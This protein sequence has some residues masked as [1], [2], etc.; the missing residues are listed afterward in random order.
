MKN[1]FCSMV[2]VGLF[3]AGASAQTAPLY[4]IFLDT[5]GNAGSDAAPH[6]GSGT[7]SYGNPN[8]PNGG[9]RLFIYG[10]FQLADQTVLS[11]N[12]DITVDGGTITG[13]WNY[14]GLGQDTLTG[15]RRWGVASPN[16]L[17]NPGGNT[18]SFTSGNII[19]M[20]LKNGIFADNF[21][22]QHDNTN[23]FGDTLLGYADVAN[24]PGVEATVWITVGQQGFAILGGNQDSGV[25]FGFGDPSVRAGDVGRRTQ[26]ADATIVP[27]PAGFMLLGLGVLA[28]TFLERI[29]TARRSS[30]IED[31]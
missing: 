18:V 27:E 23:R 13:A 5:S 7:L 24:D 31:A 9:G 1:V 16:P 20:G 25:A 11:P 17:V 29:G 14:N 10:E 6:P 28:L 21:D 2:A 4:R 19:H 22:L 3:A 12:F 15:D 26:I 30:R 8:L